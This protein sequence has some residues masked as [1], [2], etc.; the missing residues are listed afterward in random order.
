MSV[1]AHAGQVVLSI[2]VPCWCFPKIFDPTTKWNSSI[3]FLSRY[4]AESESSLSGVLVTE[5]KCIKEVKNMSGWSVAKAPTP[6]T[7]SHLVLPTR[8]K[9]L[10]FRR[11]PLGVCIYREIW[12]HCMWDV[13]RREAGL[14]GL[15]GREEEGRDALSS[16]IQYPSPDTGR[17]DATSSFHRLKPRLV[18]VLRVISSRHVHYTCPDLCAGGEWREQGRHRQRDS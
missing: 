7:P 9:C 12:Q 6:L 5:G 10:E 1:A 15:Q 4:K 11:H 18:D 16:K 14:W 17:D 3:S 2:S 8:K 13:L